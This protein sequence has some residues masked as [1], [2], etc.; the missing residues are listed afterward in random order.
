MELTFS[1]LST[2]DASK[3]LLYFN[4]LSFKHPTK[5]LGRQSPAHLHL[6]NKIFFKWEKKKDSGYPMWLS[7]KLL[8]F[9][10]VPPSSWLTFTIP[11]VKLLRGCLVFW[12][13]TIIWTT[14]HWDIISEAALVA[15]S[16]ESWIHWSFGGKP[17]Q[18]PSWRGLVA[19]AS[20]GSQKELLLTVS[21]AVTKPGKF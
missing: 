18:L 20:L 4:S 14:P 2:G 11:L 21:V 15:G 17:P 1:S 12:G 7:T 5:L 19:D 8:S 6:L 16:T 3:C 9:G 13:S 10:L